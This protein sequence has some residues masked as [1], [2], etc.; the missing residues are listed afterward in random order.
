MPDRSLLDVI[1]PEVRAATAYSLKYLEAEVKLDQNENPHELPDFLKQKITAR[2]HDLK[3]NRYPEFVPTRIIEALS[4]HTGWTGNGILV[5]NGSNEL[6]LATLV[7]TACVGRTVAIPQPTFTLYQL[8]ASAMGAPI[9]NVP[10]AADLSFDVP[11][12]TEA[13]RVSSVMVVC[14]P[15]NPTGSLLSALDLERILTAARG[16]VVVDEAYHEF[17]QQTVAPLL[18]KFENLVILRTFSK[19]MAVAGLRFGFMLANPKVVT[20]INKVKLPYNVNIFTLTAAEVL[21]DESHVVEG[22]IRVLIEEREKIRAELAL[23]PGVEAFPSRANFVLF[24]TPYPAGDLFEKL[25]A[26]SVLVRNVSHYPMLDRVLRVSIGAAHENE[27][28]LTALD[29]ALEALN[30]SADS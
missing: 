15:N 3:W 18:E 26:N 14:S 27:R 16:L 20:E 8:L 28:F 30:E 13:A 2:F 9:R 23:R 12:L 21:I 1:K 22:S 24:R 29:V 5:G 6:I 17:S 11:A 10:L 25:Y 7:A 19:A 4:R